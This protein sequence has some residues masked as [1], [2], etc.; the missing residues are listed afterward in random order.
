MA[1]GHVQGAATVQRG[2]DQ[3]RQ[4]RVVAPPAGARP[5]RAQRLQQRVVFAAVGVAD[6]FQRAQPVSGPRREQGPQRRVDAPGD[7]FQA[8]AAASRL[9]RGHAFGVQQQLVR[10][11]RPRQPGAERGFEHRLAVAQ[12]GEQPLLGQQLGE[13]L[14]AQPGAGKEFA[15]QVAGAGAE[16][17]G[18][19]GQRGRRRALQQPFDDFRAA[20]QRGGAGRVHAPH[21][22][23]AACAAHSDSCA[24]AGAGAN[25]AR[26]RAAQAPSPCR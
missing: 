8:I 3:R 4:Q 17:G 2:V 1:G 16:L 11:P 18:Q 13:A 14:R 23:R 20:A 25:S 7:D 9:R 24:D 5:L 10:A 6:E 15:L 26:A 22:S 12:R 21:C 19:L